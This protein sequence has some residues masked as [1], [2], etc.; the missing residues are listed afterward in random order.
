[1][2][3]T[4]DYPGS[5]TTFAKGIDG[6]NI[7]GMYIDVSGTSHGFLYNG[8]TYTTVDP[9]GA[10]GTFANGIDGNNIVG[11]YNDASGSSH[12]FVATNAVVPEPASV[13][14]GLIGTVGLAVLTI[15]RKC[16]R[17]TGSSRFCSQLAS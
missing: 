12:G 6:N 11:V 5:T 13:L 15:R 2:L 9:P 8:T 17:P 4:L 16:G 1:M 7:V 3:Q 14:L 10:T